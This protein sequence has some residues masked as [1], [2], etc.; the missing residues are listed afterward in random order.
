MCVC[1]AA[2]AVRTVGGGRPD[3]TSLTC[4]V[5]P[6]HQG[7]AGKRRRRRIE[8][9]LKLNNTVRGIALLY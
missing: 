4:L 2:A 9:V 6:G 7:A 5:Q 8:P 3:Q 1:D